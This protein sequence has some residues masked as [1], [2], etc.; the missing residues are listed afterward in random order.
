M[1]EQ[2]RSLFACLI[3][4]TLTAIQ[5]SAVPSLNR[6][7]ASASPKLNGRW[8]V[9]FTLAGVEKNLSFESKA[10]GV[11]LFILLD[12]GPDNRAVP[13]PAPAVWTQLTN[14]RVSFSGEAELP[15]GTCCREI[16]TLVF[17]GKFDSNDSLFGKLLF[18]TSVD[19]EESPFKYRSLVGTFTAKRMLD[20]PRA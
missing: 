9:K 19:E 16:G 3:L 13:D 17:K 15:I 5:V 6:Q 8:H 14:D 12:T 4:L 20:R 2:N 10:D 7:K 18:V 11:G 1:H